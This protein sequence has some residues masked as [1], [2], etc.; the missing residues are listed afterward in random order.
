MTQINVTSMKNDAGISSMAGRFHLA[1][2]IFTK[3]HGM[4]VVISQLAMFGDTGSLGNFEGWWFHP[5]SILGIGI[6]L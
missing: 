1:S 6:R 4:S 2:M 3:L 5:P